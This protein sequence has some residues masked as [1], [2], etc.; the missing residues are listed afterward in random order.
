[1]TRA[2]DRHSVPS[3]YSTSPSLQ[4]STRSY[5]HIL[6]FEVLESPHQLNGETSGGGAVDHAV[7]I[8]KPHRH[9]Q[10]RFDLAFAN[11]GLHGPTTQAEDGHLGLVHDWRELPTPDAALVGNGEGTALHL[12]SRHFALARFAGQFLQLSGQV[13]QSLLI[14]VANDRHDQARF[15][16]NRNPNV[17]VLLEDN[18]LRYLVEA[19]IED[20]MLLERIDNHLQGERGQGEPRALLLVRGGVLLP[21]RH[22][23]GNVSLVK[24]GDARSSAPAF[25]HPPCND[26]PQR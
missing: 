13:N 17:V 12:F 4:P 26:L 14:D 22:Q 18:L 21:Q 16:I 23:A 2:N 20:G 8:G 5:L 19:G 10:S 6:F 15:S 25:R 3:H 24:L 7:V 11:D 1:M 9:H